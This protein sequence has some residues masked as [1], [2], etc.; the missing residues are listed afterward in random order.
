MVLEC[1]A[2]TMLHKDRPSL[3]VGS[4]QSLSVTVLTRVDF[5][6][7]RHP[8]GTTVNDVGGGVGT[9]AMK[10]IKAHPNLRLKLQDLPGFIRHAEMEV[11]PKLLPSAIVDK[12]IEFKP[13]D[14]LV[15]SPIEGCDVYY[16]K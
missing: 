14:F 12:R 8:P 11:W 1:A 3:Q 10:L 9:M 2:G 5:P 16:V 7:G 4:G 13:M 6:W 15:N